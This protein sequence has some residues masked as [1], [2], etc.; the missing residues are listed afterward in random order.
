MNLAEIIKSKRKQQLIEAD[1]YDRKLLLKAI[2]NHDRALANE[3]IQRIM[4]TERKL[5]RW[6]H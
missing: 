1:K 3:I 2:D 6:T 5:E 4:K